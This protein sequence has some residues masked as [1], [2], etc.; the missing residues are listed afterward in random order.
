MW[1]IDNLHQWTTL[2]YSILT[3]FF[4]CFIYDLFRIN[5]LFFCKKIITVFIEDLLFWI[6][7]SVIIFCLMLLRTNGQI[8]FFVCFGVLIGF[9]IMRLTFS[10]LIL[11]FFK[12]FRKYILKINLIYKHLIDILCSIKIKKKIHANK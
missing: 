10:K 9:F 6:I 2:L 8:R 4:L 1:E 5:R 11:R 3:G 7:S 12:S